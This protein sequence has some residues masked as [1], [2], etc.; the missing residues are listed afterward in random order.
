MKI[1]ELSIDKS[2]TVFALMIIVL[3][4]GTFSYIG[5]PRES[6]P[7]IKIPFVSVY[8]PYYG[9]SPADMERLVTRKLEKQLK[10][11]ADMKEMTSTSA[12]GVS[13]VV[14]EFDPEVDM[15]DAL[16]KVRDAI[17]LAKPDLPDDVREDLIVREVS[18]S[19]F[20]ILQIVLSAD[21]DA[22]TLKQVAE[23][24]QEGIEQIRGV[25]GVDLAGGIEREVR[26]DAERQAL[27]LPQ[28]FQGVI[29]DSGTSANRLRRY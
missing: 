19:D 22:V 9:T 3:F 7:D 10:G 12:E 18:A 26:V 8:A 17:E 5:L 23:D 14:L 13:S 15:S 28:G 2:M 21:Y 16:Q 6:T 27:G 11:L 29:Q 4:M 20:P 25:L 24:V 1:T